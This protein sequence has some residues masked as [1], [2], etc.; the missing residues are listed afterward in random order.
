MMGTLAVKR[1]ILYVKTLFHKRFDNI[2]QIIDKR[3]IRRRLK[4]SEGTTNYYMLDTGCKLIA[5]GRLGRLLNVYVRS[6]HDLYPG[7]FFL[8][9]SLTLGDSK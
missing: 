1:L 5:H 3:D 9:K 6:I 8:I 4:F 2:C 7:V